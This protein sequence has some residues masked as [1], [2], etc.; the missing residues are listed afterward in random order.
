MRSALIS[1]NGRGPEHIEVSAEGDLIT[2]LGFVVIDPGI[3]HMGQNFWNVKT[4]S[5]TPP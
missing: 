1:S 4:F 5:L 2:L 3:G